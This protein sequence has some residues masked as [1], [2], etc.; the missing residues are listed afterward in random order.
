MPSGL[1][2]APV[3]LVEESPVDVTQL[4]DGVYLVDFG[5]VSFGNIRLLPPSG[6]RGIVTVH[7]GE[8]MINGRINRRPPGTV[9]YKKTD[10]ELGGKASVLVA[11]P[12]DARN[13]KVRSAPR[14]T[15]VLTPKEWGTVLPFRWVE[16]EGWDGPFAAESI[17]RR[18]AY[19]STWDD[20]AASFESSSEML[21]QIWELCQYS[22]K[23]TTFAGV[24][25][26]GDRERI[27][28][29][30]D[31][32]LNQLSH[33]YVDHDKQVARDTIDHLF[34]HPTWP[35]EWASHMVFMVYADYMETGDRQWLSENYERAKTKL[36]LQRRG[37]DHLVSSVR[38]QARPDLVDWP[39]AERDGYVFTERNTVVNAFHLRSL[40]LMSRLAK[41]LGKTAEAEEYAALYDAGYEAFQAAF[42]DEVKG[43][44][45]DGVRTEHISTHANLFPLAFG[46]VPQEHRKQVADWLASGG[47]KCSVYA[48]QYLME[49]FFENGNAEAAIG[50]MMAP[51]DRSWKHMVESGTTITWEA[52]DQKYKPN[53]DWN[54]AWG[55]A[56][57]NLIPRFILGVQPMEPGFAK[58]LIRPNPGT[59]TAAK[60]KI[61]TIRGPVE[62]EIENTPGTPFELA[63]TIPDGMSA[64]VEIPLPGGVGEIR[65]NGTPAKSE[66][67]EGFAV[68][69]VSSGT[70]TFQTTTRVKE[71][72]KKPTPEIIKATYGSSQKKI[73]VTAKLRQRPITSNGRVDLSGGY[74]QHF[75][76]PHHRS[77]KTLTVEFEIGGETEVRSF[78]EDSPV[79]LNFNRDQ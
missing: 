8:A 37:D 3:H 51:G 53:Q 64:Q 46:L 32:Y 27:P 26:D 47:M 39:P 73:D 14:A 21:N 63:L 22:I 12:A 43:L 72:V 25:V 66:N 59:L 30:A 33:Y 42:F 40:E 61:P 28:Y 48:A 49:A 77:V 6:A 2:A 1:S 71:P 13:T 29:E 35:T 50:L 62:V 52:W 5:K 7:F 79:G 55:A 70:H 9:R 65:H 78:Q 75:G 31:A 15:A 60:G 54:H 44:Y 17:V 58:A 68:I 74:N 11:P 4:D 24:Y 23:A 45:R 10:I 41:A 56:P 38:G 20:E 34:K 67:V 57:A 18:S 16:I 76:D 19:S 69:Q 36:L